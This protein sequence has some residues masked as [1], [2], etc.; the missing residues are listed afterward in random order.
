MSNLGDASYTVVMCSKAKV[1]ESEFVLQKIQ[2]IS[3]RVA[4]VETCVWTFYDQVDVIREKRLLRRCPDTHSLSESF[5]WINK[6]KDIVGV[7]KRFRDAFEPV[8][9]VVLQGNLDLVG[10]LTRPD[11]K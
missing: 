4:K 3:T 7:R 10:S 8:A 5:Y 1:D 6:N 2:R 9:V 11:R